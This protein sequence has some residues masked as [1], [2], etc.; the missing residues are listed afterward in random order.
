MVDYISPASWLV[1]V[2]QA[3]PFLR[4]FVG[5][6]EAEDTPRLDSH[7]AIQLDNEMEEELTKVI[8]YHR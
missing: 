2:S 1:Q 4:T 5:L 7:L 6:A 3:L 8:Q